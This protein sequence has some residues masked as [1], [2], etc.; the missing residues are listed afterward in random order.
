MT[1]MEKKNHMSRAKRMVSWAQKTNQLRNEKAARRRT[2]SGHEARE[3]SAE[4]T[5]RAR[6]KV[7]KVGKDKILAIFRPMK[8]QEM[9]M[10]SRM[11]MLD[12]S[13]SDC[14]R[15]RRWKIKI[16]K[17]PFKMETNKLLKMMKSKIPLQSNASALLMM[18]RRTTSE[19]SNEL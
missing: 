9:V 13:A 10:A 18:K 4:K 16:K 17:M 3:R 7:A 5:R 14:T 19:C 6:K 1:K 8:R 12:R 15:T 2:E 11:S